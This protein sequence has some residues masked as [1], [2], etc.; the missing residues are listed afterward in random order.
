MNL[1][2]PKK[3]KGSKAVYKSS[4][5]I[6]LDKG[7]WIVYTAH[8]TD[9][10]SCINNP[11]EIATVHSMGFYG[12]GSLS[13]GYPTFGRARYNAPP[14]IRNRQWVRRQ[15]WLQEI[16]LLGSTANTSNQFVDV[17]EKKEPSNNEKKSEE[18]DIM[19]IDVNVSNITTN[20]DNNKQIFNDNE[21]C[22]IVP[23]SSEE[24]ICIIVNKES[25]KNIDKTVIK[26]SDETISKD[27]SIDL[28]NSDNCDSV[29][30][31]TLNE[32]DKSDVQKQLLV[33]PDSD[34]ETENYLENVKPRIEMESF[35]VMESL[36]MSFEETFFLMFALDCLQLIHFDGSLMDIHSAWLYFCEED[37]NFIQNYVV[38][39]YFRSK[40]WV[41]K[42]GLKYGG[43]FLLYKQGPSFYHAS[44]IVIIDVVDADSLTKIPSKSSRKTSWSNLIGLDRL[45]ECAAKEIL[46]AQVL[47]PSSISLNSGPSNPH[48]LS[49]F[50]VREL[51]W[52]RWNPKH[53]QDVMI[54]EEE[55]DEDSC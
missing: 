13:R 49:E 44:Y 46:F 17:E 12:K 21:F 7:E 45:S 43:D 5:P 52:R 42:S 48:M 1:R 53:N 41:V 32:S 14:I 6:T 55:E 50:T 19:D 35:P 30:T 10:G 27:E 20:E 8:L 31:N 3:K 11:D 9:S 54:V 15:A 26:E 16:E 22:E 25:E 34:S 38:Y 18:S 23:S 39:H 51:L 47:W 33:L 40:G 37:K 2:E 36:H 24:D 28:D 4:I 29:T